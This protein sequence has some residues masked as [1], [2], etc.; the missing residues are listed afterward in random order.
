MY[1]QY[2]S[3]HV[4][5]YTGGMVCLGLRHR[6]QISDLVSCAKAARGCCECA[7]ARRATFLRLCLKLDFPAA[8]LN[9]VR[10]WL[11]DEDCATYERP[12]CST[13]EALLQHASSSCSSRLSHANS[14]RCA[15][16]LQGAKVS[17]EPAIG[18]PLTYSFCNGLSRVGKLLMVVL[19]E[20][21]R[22]KNH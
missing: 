20:H 11:D 6:R 8:F 15:S 19:E 22:W 4:A 18:S 3:P 10:Q 2:G 1:T 7:R 16:R 21:A 14:S 12:A 13:L 5:L 9:H 17:S